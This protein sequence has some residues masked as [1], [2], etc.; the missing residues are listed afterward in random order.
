MSVRKILA[1]LAGLTLAGGIAAVATAP[2]N[3]ASSECGNRCI[4]IFTP[5]FGHH[6]SPDYVLDSFKQGQKTGTPAILFQVSNTDPA[7]D[8]T[9]G[10][11]DTVSDYFE[12]GLVSPNVALHYGCKVPADFSTCVSSFGI[13]V[14]DWAV[15]LEYSPYGAPTGECFGVAATAVAGEQ[16]TLQP[17]GVSGKT[18]WILD[19]FALPWQDL[20]TLYLPLINGSDTNFS[21]PFV[22]TYPSGANPVDKPRAVLTVTNLQ[23]TVVLQGG[24]PTP[25]IDVNSNQLWGADVGQ[26]VP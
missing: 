9:Y 1:L 3:A 13:G 22:L 4:D 19:D 2:A 7:E 14:D 24:L 26:L 21:Q 11:P 8:I 17:C 10:T 12:A 18:L 23:G 25:V 6:H 15:E 16:V 5:Q 20:Q